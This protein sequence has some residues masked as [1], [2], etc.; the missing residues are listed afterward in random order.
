MARIKKTHFT[1]KDISWAKAFEMYMVDKER[2]NLSEQTMKNYNASFI[3][4]NKT[5]GIDAENTSTTEAL[6]HT[7]EEFVDAMRAE[8]LKDVTIN[9]H[10][11]NIH[12]FYSWLYDHNFT[13]EARKCIYLKTD[14]TLPRF[15]SDDD[16]EALVNSP[17]KADIRPTS[18]QRVRR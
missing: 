18:R 17:Y 11:G 3:K 5:F 9:T 4:Y 7:F 2:V 14:D 1:A 12:H 16:V 15:L 8:R 13:R 10:A 6:S